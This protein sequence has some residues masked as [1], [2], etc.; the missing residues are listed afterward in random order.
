MGMA[1]SLNWALA[2]AEKQKVDDSASPWQGQLI[3][4]CGWSSSL[5]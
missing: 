3:G 1:T 5:R 4:L 2:T